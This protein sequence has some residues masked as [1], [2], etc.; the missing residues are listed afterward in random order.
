MAWVIDRLRAG[1]TPRMIR[2]Q[3]SDRVP[4]PVAKVGQLRHD[5][6]VDLPPGI[7]A[8]VSCGSTYPARTDNTAKF[9]EL[10]GAFRPYPVPGAYPCTPAHINDRSAFGHR[11]VK[12]HHGNKTVDERIHTEVEPVNRFIITQKTNTLN[13]RDIRPGGGAARRCR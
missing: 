5:L 12:L 11:G 3:V 13:P 1:W 4:R 2:R 7:S 9:S 8:T 10:A 6:P